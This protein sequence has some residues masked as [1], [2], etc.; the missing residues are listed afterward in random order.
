MNLVLLEYLLFVRTHAYFTRFY[1]WTKYCSTLSYP[2]YT[3]SIIVQALTTLYSNYLLSLSA[4]FYLFYCLTT[5]SIPLRLQLTTRSYLWPDCSWRHEVI[6]DVQNTLW[7]DKHTRL[8]IKTSPIN[9]NRVIRVNPSC[10]QL[11]ADE[12][13]LEYERDRGLYNSISHAF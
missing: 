8:K 10:E 6:S 3:I 12:K 11:Q 5:S 7:Q 4:F 9:V 2:Y 1:T 13:E